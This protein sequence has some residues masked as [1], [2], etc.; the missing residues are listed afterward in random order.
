MKIIEKQK[1]WICQMN[2]NKDTSLAIQYDKIVH[3]S[4]VRRG[5]GCNCYCANPDCGSKMIARK[6]NIRAHHFAHYDKENCGKS[7]ESALHKL[8]KEII[9]EKKQIKLKPFICEIKKF[10]MHEL[11][12]ENDFIAQEVKVEKS[13]GIYKVDLLLKNNTQELIVEIFVSHKTEDDKI[14]YFKKNNL[15]AIEIDLSGLIEKQYERKMIKE[16][17]LNDITKQVWLSIKD[18]DSLFETKLEELNEEEELKKQEDL[19]RKI[20]HE[21]YME[22]LKKNRKPISLFNKIISGAVVV[23]IIALI[24]KSKK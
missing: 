3:I 14:N 9:Q 24:V 7:Y 10:G 13:C 19:K 4:E 5:L 20:E 16:I 21:K 6:G 1:I 22:E 18:Y 12:P 2:Q 23:G 15:S 8:A 17:V 11:I